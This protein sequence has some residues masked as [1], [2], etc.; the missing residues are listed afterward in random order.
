MFE[1][2]V[3]LRYL[4]AKRQEKFISVISLLAVSGVTLS[5][6]T[7]IVVLSVMSGFEKDL[8]EKILGTYSHLTISSDSFVADV[9]SLSKEIQKEKEVVAVTPY[10][11]GQIMLRVKKKVYGALIRGIDPKTEIE[12]TQLGDNLI[13]G[14]LNLEDQGVVIGEEFAHAFSLNVGDTL[15]MIAP[16]TGLPSLGLT[17]PVFT[18][19]IVGIFN[20]GMYE[21]DSRLVYVSL[22]SAQ[23][24]FGL[25]ENVHGV[26][27][28]IAD[29][30]QAQTLK[31]RLSEN[32]VP[33][34][35]VKTWM[36][37]NRNL[38]AALRTEK[39]VMFILLVMAI[40]VAAMNIASTLIMM[41]MEKTKD[42]G[43]LK[44]LGASFRIIL[45][46]FL[47][48]GLIVGVLGTVLGLGLGLTIV[49]NLD[50]I[51]NL[52]TH[53]TGF[54]VFPSDIYYLDKIPSLIHFPDIMM[55]CLA[56]VGISVL[57]S[58]YPALRAAGLKPIDALRY[59]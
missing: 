11:Y 26:N 14:S 17:P 5:V 40:A 37:L 35:N 22:E 50:S 46:I 10:I 15:S 42:I 44:S 34:L 47:L 27:V 13:A 9:P 7:L 49:K 45:N 12:A 55:I 36:D 31:R 4:L 38:F 3:S 25:G 41:V 2:F 8:K 33:P 21:Y 23:L 58:I 39:N 30:M 43:I 18:F 28:K 16:A 52:I 56:S 1:L 6:A 51:Q 32:L 48:Q 24:L 54:E 19:D 59:E 20:S 57:A 53:L 29:P